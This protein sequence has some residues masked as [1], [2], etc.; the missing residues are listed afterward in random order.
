MVDVTA[1]TEA[2]SRPVRT[3]HPANVA[4]RTRVQFRLPAR[5]RREGIGAYWFVI[6]V[7]LVFVVLFLIPLVQSFYFSLTDYNGYTDDARFVGLQNYF[8]IWSDS[9][10]VAA[11]AF[12]LIYAVATTIVVT[13]FAIPLALVLNRRFVGRNFVRSVFFFPA[14]PSVAILGLVWGFI[15]NPLG[16]GVI[17]SALG[18]VGV[19]PV[20]WLSD[21]TLAQVSVI[22][23][24]VWAQTGWHAILYLAYLQSIPGEYLEAARIDGAGRWKEF[25]YVTLP[26]LVPA[27]SVSQL[28]LLTGGL[29]VYDLP[30]TLTK[31]GPGFAT[32]TL[33]QSII[34]NGIAQSE[35]GKASALGVLFLLGVGVIIIAQL[36]IARRLQSRYS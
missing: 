26:L 30:Y 21:E 17:N 6:P 31:G 28:L 13:L 3:A 24:A 11:L 9:S 18:V 23:V 27:I 33:T 35:I 14:V 5:L 22:A 16:S 7:L 32:R 36:A 2:A 20:A 25:R 10:M 12:T 29:K 4:R 34:E 1:T 15:L 19:G 8:S